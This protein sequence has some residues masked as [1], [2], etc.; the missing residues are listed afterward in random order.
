[1]GQQKGREDLAQAML[2]RVVRARLREVTIPAVLVERLRSAIAAEQVTQDDWL[3][4]E[5]P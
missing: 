1:M 3:K 2:W 4:G 5:T